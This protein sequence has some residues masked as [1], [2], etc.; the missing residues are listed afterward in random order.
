MVAPRRVGGGGGTVP[1]V[2]AHQPVT[3]VTG[4]TVVKPRTKPTTPPLPSWWA[5]LQQNSDPNGLGRPAPVAPLSKAVQAT[6]YLPLCYGQVRVSVPPVAYGTINPGSSTWQEGQ[7][8]IAWCEGA[9]QSIDT[10]YCNGNPVRAGFANDGYQTFDRLDFTG[11]A[12]ELNAF[13][14]GYFDST[15]GRLAVSNRVEI[16]RAHV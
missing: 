2:P 5:L 4:G 12:G 13:I 16:G 8:L 6:D 15:L 11:V 14:G 7:A 1:T 9:I 3:G 10:V